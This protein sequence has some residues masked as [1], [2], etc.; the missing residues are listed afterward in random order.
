MSSIN[1]K[2]TWIT[3][4]V[5]KVAIADCVS[6]EYESRLR[7]TN[8]RQLSLQA[9]I[10]HASDTYQVEEKAVTKYFNSERAS[11]QAAS[12]TSSQAASNSSSQAASLSSLPVEFNQ[13]QIPSVPA[14]P[15]LLMPGHVSVKSENRSHSSKRIRTDDDDDVDLPS[16]GAT[17]C[18][19]PVESGSFD[20]DNWP[21][22]RKIIDVVDARQFATH[23]KNK[24]FDKIGG[25]VVEAEFWTD[26]TVMHLLNNFFQ[27]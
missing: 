25:K 13:L 27:T 1:K 8:D 15:S 10:T 5:V 2:S 12:Y 23:V 19:L 24:N 18:P 20:I 26:P 17:R 16:P 4:D 9:A 14:Y 22:Y 11:S 7:I 3:S 6:R 21:L